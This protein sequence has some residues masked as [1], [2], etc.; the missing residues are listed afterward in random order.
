MS[1]TEERTGEAFEFAERL[2]VVGRKLQP[3]ESALAFTLEHFD[4]A[5]GAM[6]R[7]DLAESA[8]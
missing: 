1:G 6:R 7:V 8:G 4:A 5:A 3:G 2:T